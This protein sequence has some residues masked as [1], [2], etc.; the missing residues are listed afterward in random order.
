[1]RAL[2]RRDRH[3]EE[4]LEALAF[5]T[6]AIHVGQE[7]DPATGAVAVPVYQTSLFVQDD[8]DQDRVWFYS[9]TGNPTRSA[10]ERCIASLEGAAHGFCFGSGV[11]AEDAVLRL[12]RPGD[13]LV[14]SRD[15]YGGTYRLLRRVWEDGGLSFTPADLTDPAAVDAA[16]RPE[17]RM[18]WVESPTNP[19]L[20]IVDIAAVAA[21]ARERGAWTV[22]DNTLASP[23][24]QQPLALGA[25]VVVHSTTKY[26]GGHSDVIGG[27]AGTSSDGLA[28][29]LEL[30]QAATGAVPGPMDAF[31]ILRGVK[32]LAVRMERHC[33]NAAAVAEFLAGHPAVADVLYPGLV[34]AP[35]PPPGRQADV[36]VR[37]DAVVHARRRGGGGQG[38]VRRHPAV[39]PGRLTGRGRV[40]DLLPAD[41]EPLPHAGHGSGRR[42]GAGAVVGGDRSGRR[43]DRRSRPGAG[44]SMTAAG[45]LLVDFPPSLLDGAVVDEA[46][47]DRLSV[48]LKAARRCVVVVGS[49]ISGL[50]LAS[51]LSRADGVAVVLV[52]GSSPIPR[53][54]V[55]GCSLR[56]STIR[57]MAAGIGTTAGQL[58]ERLGG[59]PASFRW[60]AVERAAP[61][62][63]PGLRFKRRPGTWAPADP[64]MGLSTRHGQILSG[65]R[66]LLTPGPGL[67]VV[68]GGVDKAARLVDGTG[69]PLRLPGGDALLTLPAETTVVCNATST[70]ELLRPAR[71]LPEPT[72]WVAAVQAPIRRRSAAT[73]EGRDVGIAP[74]TPGTPRPHLAFFTPF[75]DP[76]TPE[77]DWYVINTTLVRAAE[78]AEVGRDA[79][80]AATRDRMRELEA[81]YG[82]DEIDPEETLGE[83]LV[84]VDSSGGGALQARLDDGSPVV[85]VHRAFTSGAPAINVDGMLAA[86]VGADVF[87]DTFLL[88][89]GSPIDAARSA[90]AVADRSLLGIRTRN[91]LTQFTFFLA[92]EANRALTARLPRRAWQLFVDDWVRLGD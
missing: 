70:A 15:L 31:L 63:G 25:D 42:S 36:G 21:Q 44:T 46:G 47:V 10:L 19:R 20:Q 53:R 37:R 91:R 8:V 68:A 61:G 7:P 17:T 35:R 32:T 22:V 90:L 56:W 79:L 65:L 89:G 26:L 64:L 71:T 48:E 24:L 83:A 86:A 38:G 18:V 1:M 29:R 16:W 52:P 28:E 12:L 11:A 5:E 80:V 84:P 55:A 34:G 39:R 73:F 50:V 69:L 49:S 41:D 51:R 13:H 72:R 14:V 30:L 45:D 43:P 2:T 67:R 6:R 92:P 23:Y 62:A 74:M 77:A 76:D 58:H 81:H 87:A 3:P 66:S 57:R 4:E 9:R 85:D 82:F 33:A 40:A 60:L 54:L 59:P 78:L 27:W 88:A 75:A